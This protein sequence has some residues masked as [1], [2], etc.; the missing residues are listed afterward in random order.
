MLDE[1]VT[2]D[3]ARVRIVLAWKDVPYDG[4]SVGSPDAGARPRLV[5]EATLRAVERIIGDGTNLDLS[6]V[7][8]TDLGTA[9][10][11]IAEVRVAG[12][13]DSLV[14]SA[15]IREND[16]AKATARAVLDAVNRRLEL[17]LS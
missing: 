16:P 17:M 12:S 10:V 7:A 2:D 5:G 1:Q 8:T 11:A 14:G 9:R 3:D 13:L 6:G 15:V 4:D